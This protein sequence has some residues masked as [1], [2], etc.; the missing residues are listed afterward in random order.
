MTTIV[1]RAGKGGKLT[2]AEGDANFTNL[3]NDKFEAS[4]IGVAIQAYSDNLDAIA[5]L[6]SASDKGIQ[7]TGVGTAATYTLTS[8]GKALLDDANA[9]TQRTTLGSTTVG[10]A[11]FTAASAAA[12]RSA[13]GAGTVAFGAVGQ[14]DNLG[15]SATYNAGVI[16]VELTGVDGNAPSTSNPVVLTFQTAAGVSTSI[17]VT[18]AVS[19]TIPAGATLGTQ[20]LVQSYGRVWLVALDQAGAVE[21]AVKNCAGF[22]SS[23]NGTI[24]FFPLDSAYYLISTTAMSASSDSIGVA[25]STSARTNVPFTVLGAIDVTVIN[26]SL[27]GVNATYVNPAFRPGEVVCTRRSQFGTGST[28]TTAIPDDDTIPQI[29][30]GDNITSIAYT[31]GTASLCNF[32]QVKARLNFAHSAAVTVTL[33]LFNGATSAIAANQE[34]ATGTGVIT[35][36]EVDCL[37]HVSDLARPITSPVTYSVRAGGSTGATLTINGVAGAGKMGGA[38]MSYLDFAEISA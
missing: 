20:G 33:A 13:I 37:T 5:A 23:V 7:F 30:E 25:Y 3:N 38:L 35:Q 8:A 31:F 6:T 18:S 21:L 32:H 26:G 12:A 36:V 2:W 17:T 9:A 1:T 14:S 19:L 4:D 27:S 34:R 11:V 10:D 22:A 15:F 24:N 29:T 16:T 28:G